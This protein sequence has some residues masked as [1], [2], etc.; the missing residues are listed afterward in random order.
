MNTQEEV[1]F[2]NALAHE[3]WDINGPQAMLHRINPLRLR[4]IAQQQDIRGLK[5]LDVG[6]GGGILSEGLVQMGAEVTGLDLAPDLI[7]VAKAHAAEAG[8]EIAYHCAD[9]ADFAKDHQAQFDSVFCLE[10]LE[11]VE[12]YAVIIAQIASVLKPGGRVFV[13]TI[14]RTPRAFLELIVGAEYVLSWVPRGTHHYTQFIRPD[15]LCATLRTHGFTPEHLM[16]LAYHPLTK[17]FSLSPKLQP[18][19]GISARLQ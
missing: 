13:S 15:E 18:N 11:H 10:M 7:E 14:D 19:Y 6:C 16:G 17:S 3:W 12:D 2:F 9:L 8:L 1:S 4:W 5:V